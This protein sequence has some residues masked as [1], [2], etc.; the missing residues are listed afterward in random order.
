MTNE[1]TMFHLPDRDEMANRLIAVD[2]N[3]HMVRNFYPRLLREAGR[4]LP[5]FGF[6]MMMTL[7]IDDYVRSS[8]L[9]PASQ[10]TAHMMLM[11][12]RTYADKLIDNETSLAE[13]HGLL[14][15]MGVA[16]T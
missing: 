1:P 11:R 3:G 10:M 2:G 6:I 16:R 7:A 8:N 14:D 13:V 9:G 12:V 15:E 4:K 5:P